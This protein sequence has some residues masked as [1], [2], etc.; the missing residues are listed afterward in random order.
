MCEVAAVYHR[1]THKARKTYKCGECW[2]AITPGNFYERH[3]GIWDGKWAVHRLCMS[4]A[5]LYRI[6]IDQTPCGEIVQ[7]GSLYEE[8]KETLEGWYPSKD[9]EDEYRSLCS[10]FNAMKDRRR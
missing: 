2:I 1:A 4:C 7:W 9:H 5:D 10:E 6:A 3:A 8:I